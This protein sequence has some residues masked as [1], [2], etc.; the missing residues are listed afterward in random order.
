MGPWIFILDR[1]W[2]A[3]FDVG[4]AARVACAKE[5]R[6]TRSMDNS[7]VAVEAVEIVN[8]MGGLPR[9]ACRLDAACIPAAI[10][11]NNHI[12]AAETSLCECG[13]AAESRQHFSFYC[14][15]W[16]EQWKILGT[17]TGK[18]NSCLLFAMLGGKPIANTDDWNLL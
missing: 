2:V 15:R 7:Q 14:I 3:V 1:M 13:E 16:R 4:D 18:A 11:P 17:L 6:V 10:E 8:N 12:K 9:V 5:T